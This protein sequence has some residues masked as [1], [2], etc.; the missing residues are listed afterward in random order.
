MGLFQKQ[1]QE[2]LGQLQTVCSLLSALK[3]SYLGMGGKQ[4]HTSYILH[5][6]SIYESHQKKVDFFH[7]NKYTFQL[8]PNKTG[9]FSHTDSFL[10]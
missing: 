2:G 4:E 9:S 6:L 10:Q 7:T 3:Q 1:D 5:P 8:P